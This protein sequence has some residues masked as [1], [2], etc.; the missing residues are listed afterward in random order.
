MEKRISGLE[1]I[2]DKMVTLVKENIISKM[3][4]EKKNPVNLGFYEKK[5]PKN[6]RKRGRRRKP[7]IRPTKCFTKSQSKNVLT[8]FRVSI[9]VTNTMTEK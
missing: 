1:D 3:L 5:K 9:A 6:N 2:I 7:G 8:C 4:L